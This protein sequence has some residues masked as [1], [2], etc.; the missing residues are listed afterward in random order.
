M[1][2][3]D[4]VYSSYNPYYG[5]IFHDYTHE[6]VYPGDDYI[7][8]K[9]SEV[10]AE[11]FFK[12][13]TNLPSTEKDIVF[14][15]YSD[16]GY[17]GSLSIP[18]ANGVSILADELNNA[19]NSMYKLR[20]YKKL[21]FL[22][23]ACFSGSIGEAI[24]VPSTTILTASSNNEESS[25]ADYDDFLGIYL[26]DQFTKASLMEMEESPNQTIQSFYLG[27]KEKTEKSVVHI[28]GDESLRNDSISEYILTPLSPNKPSR[29]LRPTI[30]EGTPM[31]PS[32]LKKAMKEYEEEA[33]KFTKKFD[34]FLEK[35]VDKFEKGK[36]A[37]YV[38]NVETETN[39]KCYFESLRQIYKQLKR[40]NQVDTIKFRAIEKLCAK[41]SQKEVIQ[42][43]VDVGS[44]LKE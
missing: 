2:Y 13:M 18:E 26:T 35:L 7:N 23:E 29:A 4:L 40:V 11:N 41:Y 32:I 1:S 31:G 36:L 6:N 33:E 28:Y 25:S 15:Y 21:L 44:S 14:M 20:K 19:F 38:K 16:H 10:T 34:F 37:E 5:K 30:R 27:V 3:N 42:A 17:A 22:I 24:H 8:Y 39:D 12:V 43:I 9:N